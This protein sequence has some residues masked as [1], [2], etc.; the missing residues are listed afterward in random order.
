MLKRWAL[1]FSPF[2]E[3]FSKRSMWM[4]LPDF[5]LEL[6]SLPVFEALTNSIGKFIFFYVLVELDLDSGLPNS[7][8]ICVGDQSF[9]QPLDLWQEPFLYHLCWQTGHLK[10]PCSLD[11]IVNTRTTMDQFDKSLEHDTFLG[12]MQVF[13]PVFFC[14]ISSKEFFYLKNNEQWVLGIFEYFWKLLINKTNALKL[15]L[16]SHGPSPDIHAHSP[17]SLVFVESLH[18]ADHSRTPPHNL[19]HTRTVCD[20]NLPS[21]SSSSPIVDPPQLSPT[22]LHSGHLSLPLTSPLSPLR[23]FPSRPSPLYLSLFPILLHLSDSID[24][25]WLLEIPALRPPKNPPRSIEGGISGFISSRLP[26]SSSPSFSLDHN[27]T[28][29]STLRAFQLTQGVR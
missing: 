8:N 5:P 18:Q 19:E 3:S 4:I 29:P 25:M 27:C 1:G 15:H 26:P 11:K 24:R 6:L 14:N 21:T 10:K 23:Q 2:I 28:Y 17:P 22:L 16:A 12:K 20:P 13:Y 7:L 9:C